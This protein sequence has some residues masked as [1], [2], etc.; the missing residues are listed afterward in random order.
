MDSEYILFIYIGNYLYLNKIKFFESKQVYKSMN[1]QA[2]E[3]GWS[4]KVG[5]DQNWKIK[6]FHFK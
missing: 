3:T 5:G 1:K 4:L 6:I 2:S